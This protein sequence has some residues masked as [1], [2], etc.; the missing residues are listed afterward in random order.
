MSYSNPNKRPNENDDE[1][2][3][4]TKFQKTNNSDIAKRVT[5]KKINGRFYLCEDTISRTL[6]PKIVASII[7]GDNTPAAIAIKFGY[8]SKVATAAAITVSPNILLANNKA[9]ADASIKAAA[10]TGAA[11]VAAAVAAS[12][13]VAAYQANDIVNPV[14]AELA[15]TKS[16]VPQNDDTPSSTQ[17]AP[18]AD[19]YNI[20]R[21]LLKLRANRRENLRSAINSIYAA[22]R[23][24][25]IN[26]MSAHASQLDESDVN[27]FHQCGMTGKMSD[28][29]LQFT[30][31]EI[32]KLF[33]ADYYFAGLPIEVSA[34]EGK[35]L[36]IVVKWT[37]VKQN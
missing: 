35:K 2:D 24:S 10:A 32:S 28:P 14:S 16:D 12:A 20:V 34:Y 18:R 23:L 25:I 33:I 29:Q 4:K 30:A 3:K 21:H 15:E 17:F 1:N 13:T 36:R 8:E 6:G 26:T 11:S 5:I 19:E 37:S 9:A 7:T 31:E 27:Y 22:I